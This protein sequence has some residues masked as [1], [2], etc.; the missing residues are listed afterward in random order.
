MKLWRDASWQGRPQWLQPPLLRR[1]AS[2]SAHG[3]NQA[4]SGSGAGGQAERSQP[5]LA[6]CP[7]GSSDAVSNGGMSQAACA[8]EQHPIHTPAQTAI[9]PP[10]ASSASSNDVSPQCSTAAVEPEAA[11]PAVQVTSVSGKSSSDQ[12]C[13][14]A[15][16]GT[17]PL[18]TCSS[19]GVRATLDAPASPGSY[20]FIEA[21]TSQLCD[22]GE[23]SELT[24]VGTRLLAYA[25][26]FAMQLQ[27]SPDALPH[28][29]Q[30]SSRATDCRLEQELKLLELF[31][32]V[33]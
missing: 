10:L 30:Q 1:A 11:P 26:S 3:S 25:M 5:S 8:S 31:E 14:G 28:F 2:P 16:S 27:V 7:P 23:L 17:V 32:A 6:A 24:D 13:P 18:T 4:K 12:P 29:P 15:T 22:S 21:L 9:I 20:P 19:G 33:A